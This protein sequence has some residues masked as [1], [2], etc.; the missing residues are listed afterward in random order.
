M[1]AIVGRELLR[2]R[3]IDVAA[4]LAFWTMMSMIPLLMTVVAVISLLHLPSLIPE[5][6]SVLA[7]LV[8]PSALTM[9][10]R[11]VAAL[12]TPHRGVLSFGLLSYIWSSTGGFTSLI[13]ALDI[14]YDVTQERS[15]VRDRLQAI[16]LTFTSGG[17]LTISLLALVAGPDFARFV[18]RLM[19]VP[20]AFARLWPV[21]RVGTVFVCFVVA[22]ELAYFLG[23]NL[24]QRFKS[25]LPGAIFS[26]AVWFLGSAGLAF[27]LNHLS[28]FSK[29]Y[30]GMG[31]VLALM[32]WI[33]LIALATL[34]GAELNAE[35][36]KRWDGLVRGTGEVKGEAE[37]P[38]A[39]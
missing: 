9:V 8:P 28:N 21:I 23:P 37:M 20:P 12:L 6:L 18:N 3:A 11:M 15:W 4:G 32:F 10:E 16:L 24:K 22:L 19:A 35:L 2:T 29:L 27:Y 13:A 14:A 33:Y 26:I 25:T 30:G 39:A 7:M 38:R 34:A 31:A 17:L 1:A 5:M 36:A